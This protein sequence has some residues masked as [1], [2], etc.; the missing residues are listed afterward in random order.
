MI[1]L[2]EGLTK[3][4]TGLGENKISWN[5]ECR[6]KDLEPQLHANYGRLNRNDTPDHTE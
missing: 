5:S 3:D 4:H 6:V 2:R 1:A